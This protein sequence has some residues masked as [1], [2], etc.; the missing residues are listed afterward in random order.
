MSEYSF[1][2]TALILNQQLSTGVKGSFVQKGYKKNPDV[3]IKFYGTHT[4]EEK[5]HKVI[6]VLGISFVYTSAKGIAIRGDKRA[7]N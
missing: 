1:I 7:K 4:Y 5:W 6:S 2:N 3:K